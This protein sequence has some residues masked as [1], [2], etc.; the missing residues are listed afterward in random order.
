MTN[1]PTLSQFEKEFE[2]K[3]RKFLIDLR[4]MRGKYVP[5]LGQ[6]LFEASIKTIGEKL[7]K[8]LNH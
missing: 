6:E 7:Q 1:Q 3:F 2:K 5:V 8:E 4:N